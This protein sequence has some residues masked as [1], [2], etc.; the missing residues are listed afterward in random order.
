[1]S[2][3]L[4]LIK[5]YFKVASIL[6]PRKAAVQAANLFQKVRIKN[7]REREKPFFQQ[8]RHY[9]IEYAPEKIF[10]Y[11]MGD[12]D[13][14]PIFLLHGWDSNAGSMS[15]IAE[16]LVEKGYKIIAMNL[17]G[18]AFSKLRNNNLYESK[19]AFQALLNHINPTQP[20]IAISHSF[21]SG[22]VAAALSNN[23]YKVDKLVF[24][25]TPNRFIDFFADFKKMIGLGDKSY[26]LL[27]QWASDILHEDLENMIVADKLKKINFNHLL[28]IHDRNDKVLPYSNTEEIHQAIPN[29]TIDD[30][31]SVGHYRMLWNKEVLQS[32]RE[33]V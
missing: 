30:H 28:L 8:A 6:I 25:T 17:P 2:L 1:M 19:R 31:V 16:T 11:E 20:I 7:I 29:S 33:F 22:A 3:Q 27:C 14:R 12:K 10:V 24:L 9:T 4:I 13:A 21:G 26:K 32:I 15:K 18:H 23:D 5:S